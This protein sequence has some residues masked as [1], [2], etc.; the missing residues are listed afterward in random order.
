MRFRR[1]RLLILAALVFAPP[2][3]GGGAELLPPGALA[4]LGT[5]RFR[6][7][8]YVNATA[9]SPDGKLVA[10]G[11]FQELRLLD[12]RTGEVV[13]VL[14][15][16]LG[17]NAAA[18]AFSPDGKTLAAVASGTAI[19]LW[20]VSTGKQ[21]RQLQCPPP[22]PGPPVMLAA[23][24]FSAD[25]TVVAAGNDGYGQ[26]L[27]AYAWQVGS[28]QPLG[29]FKLIQ[30]SR[31][32]VALS[33]NGKVL[34]SW[35]H[36]F[37]RG[38]RLAKPGDSNAIQ[39]WDTGTGKELRKLKVDGTINQVTAAGFS[40]D[41]KLLAVRTGLSTV[42]LW[43][44]AAGTVRHRLAGRSGYNGLVQFSPDGKL[45]AVGADQGLLQL[46][47]TGSWKRRPPGLGPACQLTGLAFP[48][49][50]QVLACGIDGP[51]ICVWDA[52]DGK[53]RGGSGG[54]RQS[55]RAIAFAAGGR[56]LVSVGP[57]STVCVWDVAAGRELR[58]FSLQSERAE[59]YGP[60]ERVTLMAL[61]PDGKYVAA[62]NLYGQGGIRLWDAATGKAV[63][64]F[65]GPRGYGQG[66]V[67][68]SP[69]GGR[70]AAVGTDKTVYLWDVTRGEELRRLELPQPNNGS[71]MGGHRMAF[72]PDGKRL[73]LVSHQFRG[74][75][76]MVSEVYLWDLGTGKELARIPQAMA[77]SVA[78]SADGAVLAIGGGREVTLWDLG[79]GAERRRLQGLDGNVMT[80]AFAPDGRTLAGAAT[81]F[82]AGT[83]S[84]II[85]VWEL[86]AGQL[87]ARFSGHEGVGTCLAF[88][89]DSKILASG[90]GDTT[91]LIWDMT[92]RALRPIGAAAKPDGLWQDLA[93]PDPERA[94]RALGGLVG[95]PAAALP[96]LKERL[97][98]AAAQVQDSASVSKLIADLDS[99][100]SPVRERAARELQRL[101]AAAA[102][103]L[104]K[105]AQG[106]LTV[107]HRRRVEGLLSRL[108]KG[109]PPAEELRSR[110]AVEALE[111]IGTDAARQ[112]LK[113]LADGSPG[114]PLTAAA[115]AALSRLTRPSRSSP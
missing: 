8:T 23:P 93:S 42:E 66:A 54:H 10:A 75:A 40:A 15:G 19:V 6:V 26:F 81:S 95:D 74:G 109:S 103:A 91:I 59:R 85:T 57:D 68:F 16:S 73:A 32:R 84:T 65:E 58:H 29:P 61:S 104:Q 94:F 111:R 47:E 101:G 41:G 3:A 49:A 50:G 99:P 9:L 70:L 14:R 11:N 112:Q 92:G 18:L 5:T 51:T 4:R 48:A 64:D 43:D 22:P 46:W 37:S 44:V 30:N 113:T 107:E 96:L 38:D 83:Q 90:N 7:G 1:G 102:P 89:P 87:R 2:A 13:R 67:V 114:V 20:D 36:Y 62:E 60:G 17:G 82:A 97:R 69:D 34:A 55:V 53:V 105:A 71:G 63:C 80:V 28:G 25:G 115:R 56:N 39:L 78:F 12:A 35:G 77:Q 45:L 100:R 76:G 72:S 106:E 110:R 33:P 86:S 24:V 88:S 31:V 21:R 108:E 27:S 98:P 79:K 52:A